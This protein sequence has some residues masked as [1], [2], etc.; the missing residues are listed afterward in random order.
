MGERSAGRRRVWFWWASAPWTHFTAFA[1]VV[2]NRPWPQ[3]ALASLSS[4]FVRRP[5]GWGRR[6]AGEC[7]VVWEQ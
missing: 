3:C 2:S 7:G 1:S 6:T 4:R 5:R